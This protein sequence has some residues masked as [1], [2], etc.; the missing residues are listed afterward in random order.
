ML[1]RRKVC[2]VLVGLALAGSALIAGAGAQAAKRQPAGPLVVSQA[3]AAPESAFTSGAP[4]SASAACVTPPPVLVSAFI[5]C[6]T[7]AQIRAAYGVDGVPN[8]G[9]GQTIV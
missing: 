4:T 5:H 7:P 9:A 1:M 3:I 8:M 2:L 6:Y